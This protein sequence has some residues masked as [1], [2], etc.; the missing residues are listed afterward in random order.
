[1][2]RTVENNS[3]VM[4]AEGALRRNDR[5]SGDDGE[6]REQTGRDSWAVR[7]RQGLGG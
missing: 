3:R 1:M 4:A 2:V 6:L 5:Y 7:R